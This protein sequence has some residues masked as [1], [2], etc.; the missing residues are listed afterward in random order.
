MAVIEQRIESFSRDINKLKTSDRQDQHG[1][2]IYWRH[3]NSRLFVAYHELTTAARTDPEL[4]AVMKKATRKF[5]ERW[6][7]N[8]RDL[9]PEW[10]NMGELFDLA[11]DISQFTMEGMALNRLSHD[12]KERQERIREYLKARLKDII[13]AGQKGDHDN[14]VRQFLERNNAR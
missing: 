13:S 9:F 1:I 2:D 10:N 12:V 6:F 11:M 4:N 7:E 3:L 8:I 14:A 5:E